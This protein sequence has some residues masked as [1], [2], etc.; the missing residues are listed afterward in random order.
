MAI[1]VLMPF[2]TDGGEEGVV[3]AWMVDE[4]SSVAT[5]ALIAEVQV[6]KVSQDVLAPVDGVVIG[7]VP[8]NHPTAQGAPICRIVGMDELM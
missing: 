1:E 3:T 4:G 7:L 8:I 2:I 6:E 5:G